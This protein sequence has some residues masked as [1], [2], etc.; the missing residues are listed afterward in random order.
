MELEHLSMLHQIAWSK[1][2]SIFVNKQICQQFA[3]EIFQPMPKRKRFLFEKKIQISQ[4][5]EL[6]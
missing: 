6:K 2:R 5:F 1:I 4:K 3:A